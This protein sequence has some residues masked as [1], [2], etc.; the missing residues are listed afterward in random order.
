MP[1]APHGDTPLRPS[2]EGHLPAEP[3]ALA[4]FFLVSASA[5]GSSR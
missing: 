5:S 4:D 3:E 1:L 2:A